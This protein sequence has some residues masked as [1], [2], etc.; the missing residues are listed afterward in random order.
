MTAPPIKRSY[1]VVHARETSR[2]SKQRVC[3]LLDHINE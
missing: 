3:Q 2:E 1:N